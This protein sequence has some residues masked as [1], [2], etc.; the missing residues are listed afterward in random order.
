MG[1]DGYKKY[2]IGSAAYPNYLL[3]IVYPGPCV[4]ALPQNTISTL[5]VFWTLCK[6]HG[7]NSIQMGTNID[8][9][10]YYLWAYARSL[11]NLVFGWNSYFYGAP[12]SRGQWVPDVALDIEAHC[13]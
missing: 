9:Q 12:D 6:V 7:G 10:N 8:L 3:A 4:R 1:D 5:D 2:V 13:P 11:T